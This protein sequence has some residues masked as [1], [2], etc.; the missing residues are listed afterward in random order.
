[1]PISE[2]E[3]KRILAELQPKGAPI[4][5]VSECSV[6]EGEEA[7]QQAEAIAEAGSSGVAVA[8]YWRSGCSV[9]VS[10]GLGDAHL[11]AANEWREFVFR[12]EVLWRIWDVFFS[13][14]ASL[15]ASARFA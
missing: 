9:L 5:I 15:G 6:L 7:N 1:M 10:T 12:S 13:A 2:T 4:T 8:I 3:V 14:L 11:G